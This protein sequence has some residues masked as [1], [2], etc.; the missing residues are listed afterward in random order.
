MPLLN[1]MT[2][3]NDL[4]AS[5]LSRLDSMMQLANLCGTCSDLKRVLKNRDLWL[6]VAMRTTGYESVPFSVGC[7]NFWHMLKLLLC[8]WLSPGQ[9]FMHTPEE[10]CDEKYMAFKDGRLLMECEVEDYEENVTYS[11]HARPRRNNKWIVVEEEEEIQKLDSGFYFEGE[12]R[13]ER[14]PVHASACAIAEFYQ[15]NMFGCP[16]NNGIYF[17]STRSGEVLRHVK[18][19]NMSSIAMCT[20]PCEMWISTNEVVF[21]F[22]LCGSLLDPSTRL[23]NAVYMVKKGNAE[24]VISFLFE[25]LKCSIDQ[26]TPIDGRTVLHIAAQE[27]QLDVAR[28]ILNARADPNSTDDTGLTP[29]A[30]AAGMCDCDMIRLLV[31]HKADPNYLLP[32]GRTMVD[33]VGKFITGNLTLPNGER[34]LNIRGRTIIGGVEG[35]AETC[36]VLFGCGCDRLIS[37]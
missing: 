18:L 4:L 17:I 25:Q 12:H 13:H 29:L 30:I 34:A 6:N 2:H 8:P 5:V 15:D 21:Y 37:E 27:A 9:E 11:C 23:G 14:F 7:E 28:A 10:W 32:E 35:R 36:D 24:R 31:E 1:V 20:A 16:R 26:P 33:F 22:G 3:S 19:E